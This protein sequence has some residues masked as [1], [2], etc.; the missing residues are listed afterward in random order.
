VTAVAQPA[1]QAEWEMATDMV[2]RG[3]P[4]APLVLALAAAGW[5]VNGSLSA[6]FGLVLVLA[7][8]L[9][10]AALMGWGGRRSLGVLATVAV[11]GFAVR[12]ALVTF[13]V[14]A[15]KDQAWVE[16]VPLGVTILVTQLGLLWW[17]TRHVSLTL[18]Y[19][20]LKPPSGRS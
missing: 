5:G 16:L 2:R 18:A 1:A 10:A 15:V 19:P 8:L 3:L 17:E 12:V 20:G 14:W 11:G 4:A 6:A 13:A 7:N 9:V